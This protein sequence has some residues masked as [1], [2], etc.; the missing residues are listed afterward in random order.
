LAAMA[1]SLFPLEQDLSCPVCF[2]IF[3]DPVILSCSHSFCR[4]CLQ[5]SWEEKMERECPVCRCQSSEGHLPTN[6]ALRSASHGWSTQIL[7][8]S[9]NR[10]TLCKMFLKLKNNSLYCV[11]ES[12]EIIAFKSNFQYKLLFLILMKIEAF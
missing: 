4:T 7:Y 9:E 6:L 8:L 12:T 11:S 2:E 3:N 10:D 1:M 5:R